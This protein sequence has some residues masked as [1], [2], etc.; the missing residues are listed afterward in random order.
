VYVNYKRNCKTDT[1]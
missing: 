1:I